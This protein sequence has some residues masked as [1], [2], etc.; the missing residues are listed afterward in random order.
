MVLCVTTT[1]FSAHKTGVSAPRIAIYVGENSRVHVL[2]AYNSSS[3][4]E[5]SHAFVLTCT[6]VK[7]ERDA[8]VKHTMF[9]EKHNY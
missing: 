2:E 8:K 4:G 5:E 7:I 1:E 9:G 3:S 6:A